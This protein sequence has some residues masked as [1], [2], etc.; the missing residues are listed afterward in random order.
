M[1]CNL[2]EFGFGADTFIPE[3]VTEYQFHTKLTFILQKGCDE[4]TVH[5]VQT[6][7]F[8]KYH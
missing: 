8:K 7:L 3:V 4:T 2:L 6:N 1:D 5:L